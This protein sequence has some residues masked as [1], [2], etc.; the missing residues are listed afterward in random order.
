MLKLEVQPLGDRVLHQLLEQLIAGKLV[1]GTRLR[2]VELAA[3]LG[4]S[5]TPVREGAFAT[6]T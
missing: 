2:E 4:V 5:R 6:R 1:P 3:Q